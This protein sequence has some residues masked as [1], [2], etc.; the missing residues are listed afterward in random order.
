MLYKTFK[1]LRIVYFLCV[2]LIIVAFIL[3]TLYTSKYIRS[4]ENVDLERWGI[5]LTLFGIYGILK[6]LHPKVKNADRINTE[7][8]IKKYATK[9][10]VRL[11]S[12]L[13]LCI[14]NLVCLNI[15]GIK[16]FTFLSIITI[17]AMFLCIPNKKHL[18]EETKFIDEA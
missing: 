18:E 1:T 4:T 5:I 12:L 15:T 8:A 3:D 9:F 16:N 2:I 11:A 7:Y 10:Y 13:G 6:M 14:F 17:F